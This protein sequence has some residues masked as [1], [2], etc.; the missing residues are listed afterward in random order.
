M[1]QANLYTVIEKPVGSEDIKRIENAVDLLREIGHS[2]AKCTSTDDAYV[3]F[4]SMANT[5]E[6]IKE[7][8]WKY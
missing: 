6:V 8:N 4:L 1:I 7:G 3:S 2:I 5:L